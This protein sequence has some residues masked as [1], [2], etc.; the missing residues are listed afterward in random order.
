MF[1]FCTHVHLCWGFLFVLFRF[2]VLGLLCCEDFSLAAANK[3]YSL[4][5]VHELLIVVASLVAEHRL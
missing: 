5:A 3:S 1:P 4:V 2:A